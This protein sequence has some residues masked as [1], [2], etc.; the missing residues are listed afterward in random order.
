[1]TGC[2]DEA[3][4][5]PPSERIEACLK[6]LFAVPTKNIESAFGLILGLIKEQS[7]QIDDLKRA[8]AEALDGGE[9]VRSLLQTSVDSLA[10][11]KEE[12]SVDF[13]KLKDDHAR[14]LELYDATTCTMDELKHSVEVSYSVLV[15]GC[16]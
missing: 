14:L 2:G 7:G 3:T 16:S 4:L 10:R 13:H 15:F 9:K 5:Q 8:H 12:L 6:G 1:M 11:E